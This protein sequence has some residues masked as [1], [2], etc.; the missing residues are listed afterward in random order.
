MSIDS[1][2]SVRARI[3]RSAQSGR[4]EGM[5]FEYWIGGGQPP[6]YYRSDQLRLLDSG[7]GDLLVFARP[8]WDSAFDP[9]DLVEKF[10]R[11][12]DPDEI[13]RVLNLLL[14]SDVFS[15]PTET[16]M[17]GPDVLKTEIMLTFGG[18]THE[19]RF[20]G[21]IP[22]ELNALDAV[23]QALHVSLAHTGMRSVTHV[24]KSVVPPPVRVDKR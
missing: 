10:Q 20:H 8:Y 6:P 17:A 21:K 4:M 15:K 23:V 3:D 19:R 9:P 16:E 18:V 7:A 13:R 11:T 5:E 24:G 22:D 2:D 12:A 14:Q 1:K